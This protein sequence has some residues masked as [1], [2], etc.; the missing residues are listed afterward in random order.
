MF[1]KHCTPK[2]QVQHNEKHFTFLGFTA[3][4]KEPVLC[5]IIIADVREELS[6]ET[7]IDPVAVTTGGVTDKYFLIRI[8]V[9]VNYTPVDPLAFLK[10]NRFH[11]W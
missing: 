5:L 11:I 4:S 2:E 3:L 10:A 1:E 7:G 8:S 9:R 6:V